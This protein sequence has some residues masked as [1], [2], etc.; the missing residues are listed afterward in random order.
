M[1]GSTHC[2]SKQNTDVY[3]VIV[4]SKFTVGDIVRF[5]KIRRV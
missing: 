5:I 1:F 2:I 3:L 4:I